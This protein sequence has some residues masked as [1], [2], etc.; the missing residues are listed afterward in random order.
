M[1]IESSIE[2]KN[3]P[4]G[5]T[6]LLFSGGAD[7]LIFNYLLNPD[8]L[9][10]LPHGNKYEREELS[11]IQNLID[12]KIIDGKKVIFNRNL[13]IGDW[14]RVDS[15][16]PTRNLLF[17][18]LATL[19]GETIY[20]GSVYGDRSSDKSV[21]FFKKCEDIFNYIY[22]ESHWCVDRKFK[23]YSPFKEYT[24][25]ELVRLYLEKGGDPEHLLE[26]YSCYEGSKPDGFCKACFRK[27]VS[28]EN[29]NINTENYF[30]NNPWEAPWLDEILPKILNHEYRGRED[31][32]IIQALKKVGRL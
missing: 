9:L 11:H 25:T 8:I 24:K 13:N 3:K 31:D 30:V 22:Q 21:E 5:K 17:I 15:I 4:T 1:V 2:D 16:I 26:S 28:L 7:S 29:N 14:E 23:I 6:V 20:L 10:V 27:W 19:Y 12:K 32:D 18:D